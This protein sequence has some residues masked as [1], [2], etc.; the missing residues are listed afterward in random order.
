M[1][2]GWTKKLLIAKDGDLVKSYMI[3]LCGTVIENN[4]FETPKFLSSED[5]AD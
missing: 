2:S 1:T 4:Y 5:Y 3:P